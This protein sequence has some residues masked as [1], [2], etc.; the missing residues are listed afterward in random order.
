MVGELLVAGTPPFQL[1]AVNQSVLVAP[2]QLCACAETA[3]PR[4][5]VDASSAARKCAATWHASE[6]FVPRTLRTTPPQTHTAPTGAVLLSYHAL[7]KRSIE[8]VPTP[9]S[10]SVW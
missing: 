3:E 2:V 8:S 7:R 1:P 10:M 9:S 5:A 4:S 6:A